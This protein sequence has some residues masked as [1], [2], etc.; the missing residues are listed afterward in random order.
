MDQTNLVFADTAHEGDDG[1]D[2]RRSQ[3]GQRKKDR[4]D[5]NTPGAP[6][7]LSFTGTD[8]QGGE[9]SPV[10][11]FQDE[12]KTV[13]SAADKLAGMGEKQNDGGCICH[14]AVGTRSASL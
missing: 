13:L 5:V 14:R 4:F 1:G 3:T 12:K 11:M 2:G 7:H 8:Q 6:G 9:A 10:K